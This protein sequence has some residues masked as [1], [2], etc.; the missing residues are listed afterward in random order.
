MDKKNTMLLTVIAVATLL[1]AVVGATFAFFSIT[2]DVE[3]GTQA[4]VVTTTPDVGTVTLSN[5]TNNA[6]VINLAA[7][8]MRHT[9]TTLPYWSVPSAANA[10]YVTT[11][12]DKPVLQANVAGGANDA[13]YNCEGNLKA[14]LTM[15]TAVNAD[16]IQ[17]ADGT[18]YIVDTAGT[19]NSTTTQSVTLKALAA[20]G[21][22]GVEIPYVINGLTN[23]AALNIYA[24]LN[25][26]NTTEAQNYLKDNTFTVT[27]TAPTFS[28]KL[29]Q[30]S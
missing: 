1:V 30:N 15:A 22:T 8:D 18:L 29:V 13:V 16:D 28:C 2:A 3:S 5:G 25:I 24:S 21:S 20:A 7:A 27:I 10:T 4:T 6:L 23:A 11:R 14:V 19:V 12:D 9:T 17:N 26:N